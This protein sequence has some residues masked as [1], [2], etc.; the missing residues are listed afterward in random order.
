MNIILKVIIIKLSVSK[1]LYFRQYNEL[2]LKFKKNVI[3]LSSKFFFL[4]FFGYFFRS[5]LIMLIYQSSLRL[6][7]ILKYKNSI[8]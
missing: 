2:Y 4:L 7:E 1:I 3:C 8:V 5:T 6:P